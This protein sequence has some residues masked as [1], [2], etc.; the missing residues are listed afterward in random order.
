MTITSSS[1]SSVRS[2]PG[3]LMTATYRFY[4]ASIAAVI[5]TD[6]VVAVGEVRSNLFDPF[7]CFHLS[8]TARPFIFPHIFFFRDISTL[9]ALSF[10]ILVNRSR[11]TRWKNTLSCICCISEFVAFVSS[12]PKHF[13]PSFKASC[14]NMCTRRLV[15]W[16]LGYLCSKFGWWRG[17]SPGLCHAYHMRI[18]AG[19]GGLTWNSYPP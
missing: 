2:P 5:R 10:W 11:F 3:A 18:S 17:K 1:W 13:R 9:S 4:V 15:Y 14:V 12:H 16:S 6:S 7:I 8:A 19:G